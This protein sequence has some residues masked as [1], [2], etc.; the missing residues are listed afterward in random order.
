[1]PSYS[2]FFLGSVPLRI[3]GTCHN[4]HCHNTNCLQV[5]DCVVGSF[6]LSIWF[7]RFKNSNFVSLNFFFNGNSCQLFMNREFSLRLIVRNTKVFIVSIVSKLLFLFNL[8]T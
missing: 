1:M 3:V 4:I 5:F 8:G 7:L 6:S 2:N